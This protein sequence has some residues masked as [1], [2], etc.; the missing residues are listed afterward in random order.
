MSRITRSILPAVAGLGCLLLPGAARAQ[1]ADEVEMK[2]AG[3]PPA[4]RA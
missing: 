1:T 2:I 3:L 4:E